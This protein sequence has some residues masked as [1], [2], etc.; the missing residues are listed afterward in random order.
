MKL[1]K[2]T[3]FSVFALSISS[4]LLSCKPAQPASRVKQI[5]EEAQKLSRT[6]LYKKAAAELGSQTF[7]WLATSSRGGKV[8]DKFVKALNDAAGTSITESQI[9]YQTTVDG[10]V[11]TIINGDNE[12]G[13]PTISGALLQDGYQLQTK[14]IEKGYINYVPKEWSEHNGVNPDRDSNPF[15]LQF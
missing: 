13:N 5:V 14:G 15:T 1:N 12:S 4:G 8:K 11:Y 6:E 2:L 7:H 10:R 9:D 3:L